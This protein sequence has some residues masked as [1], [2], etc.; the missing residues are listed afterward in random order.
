[1]NDRTPDTATPPAPSPE[2][3]NALKCLK[4]VFGYDG[5]RGMQADVVEQVIGGKDAVVL[6]PT[7]GGKSICYQVPALVRPGMGL[8]ISPLIALMRDQVEALKQAGVNAAY[9]NSSQNA[10]EAREVGRDIRAGRIELLYVSPERAV[11]DG[12]LDFM[13]DVSLSVIAIDEAHCVSQ[14]GHDFRPEYRALAVLGDRFPDVPRMALTAT[15][16]LQTRQ[17]IINQLNLHRATLFVSSFDRKNISLTVEVKENARRRLVD[18]VKKRRGEAGIVYCGTRKGVDST[19]EALVK[20]G[21]DALAYHAGKGPQERNEV[22]DRFILEEGVVVVATLAFGMGIDKSNVRYVVHMDLPRSIEA[23]YQEIGRAGRDGEPADAWML[24]GMA[25]VVRQRQMI[26]SSDAPDDIKRVERAKLDA[27]LGYC[28]APQ[29]RRMVLL[30]YLGETVPAGARCEN[31]DVCNNPM[32]TWDATVA[33]KALAAVY[34][35]GQRFGAHHVVD[36]LRG[37]N[38]ERIRQFG[39]DQIKTYGVGADMSKAAWMSVFRQLTA[40]G[41]LEINHEAYGALTV[42]PTGE[43]VLRAREELRLRRDASLEKPA[44]SSRTSRG[45]A[46]EP[47]LPTTR[48]QRL[49]DHLR[50]T[51]MEIARKQ[52]VPPYVVFH[53]KTLREMA[54]RVP[55][56]A[57]EL[58]EITGV[59]NAKARKYG[60]AFLAALQ[61]FE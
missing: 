8:V 61:E 31:C 18:F 46:S 1:M 51:R 55:T 17:D 19:A 28:E 35:T 52:R 25:D 10:D 33:Q 41:Y 44:G 42:S 26:D 21:I 15:A 45:S 27:L 6:M 48:S 60:E 54:E 3:A 16:D 22:Q 20:A 56:T 38:T 39:H 36:V 2:L 53:D 47:A 13:S 23:Y 32:E 14:W 49:F 5:F 7:G 24:Y 29:C 34:R 37:A 11:L 43:D 12:F 57:D 40:G 58:L 50:A 9:L 59:S 30:R 4:D